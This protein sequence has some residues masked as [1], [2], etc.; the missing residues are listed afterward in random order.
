MR[1]AIIWTNDGLVYWHIYA[2]LDRNE[3]NQ[4]IIHRVNLL[5]D[6]L[7]G[8]LA[9]GFLLAIQIQGK[10]CLAIIKFCFINC[11]K[12]PSN[13]NY[14]GKKKHLPKSPISVM[15]TCLHIKKGTLQWCH[16]GRDGISNHQP[17]DCLLNLFSG[18]DQRKHQSYASLAFVWG[19]H[20]WPVNSPHK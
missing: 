6:D 18:A 8:H 20:Q 16:N 14:F 19:I 2:T 3:L 13:Y 15:H 5:I 7:W 1:P 9:N 17:H 11:K 10:L 4:F 12:F